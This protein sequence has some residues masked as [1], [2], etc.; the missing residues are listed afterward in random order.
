MF[1]KPLSKLD[2]PN[3]IKASNIEIER[4]TSTKYLGLIL[5]E[6]LKWSEHIQQVVEW[7]RPW[8]S[9]NAR[10]LVI[11]GSRVRFPVGTQV[12]RSPR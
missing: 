1:Y 9:G 6:H 8:V 11:K 10:C 12:V 2:I 7:Y 4:V 3:K 5:N